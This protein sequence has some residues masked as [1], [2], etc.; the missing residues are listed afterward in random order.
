MRSLLFPV[1]PLA[2]GDRLLR[3]DS[4]LCALRQRALRGGTQQHASDFCLCPQEQLR[5]VHEASVL[6]V[7][8]PCIKRDQT[9]AAGV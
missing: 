8:L 6:G 3:V 7:A 4:A 5:V 1:M 9:R 2:L